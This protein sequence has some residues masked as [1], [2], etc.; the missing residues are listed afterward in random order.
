MFEIIDHP[1]DLGFRA[2]AQ[3]LPALFEQCA[4][5][6]SSILTDIDVLDG[7]ECEAVS[8]TGCDLE[9][10]LYNWL[11][12]VLFLFDGRGMLFC[13]FAV[14][15]IEQSPAGLTLAARLY[16]EPYDRA[17]HQIKT[18]VKAVTFHQLAVT[19]GDAGW[20]AIVYLDI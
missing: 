4:V 14:E 13:G 6:L 9:T 16:G 17:R 18:Y 19:G 12:E 8:L 10:L 15:A 2:Q 5:A 3:D 11:S 20:Q 1:A 7:K